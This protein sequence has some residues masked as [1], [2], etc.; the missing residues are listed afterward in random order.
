[1]SLAFAAAAL[2]EVPII[3]TGGA[4]A[5]ISIGIGAGFTA[6]SNDAADEGRWGRVET[7]WQLETDCNA[8]GMPPCSEHVSA[9]EARRD[10]GRVAATAFIGAGLFTVATIVYVAFPRTFARPTSLRS[11]AALTVHQW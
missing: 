6:A 5:L 8:G 7:K 2:V 9:E 11:G 10:Y 4:L 1:L 3:V